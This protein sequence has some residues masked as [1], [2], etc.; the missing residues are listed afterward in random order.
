MNTTGKRMALCLLFSMMAMLWW[1]WFSV[2]PTHAQSTASLETE[3]VAVA[4]ASSF[5]L[6]TG[7][8]AA[9]YC[10]V[11]VALLGEEWQ[12]A[13]KLEATIIVVNDLAIRLAAAEA[14][15]AAL[16]ALNTDTLQPQID[17]INA[18]LANMAVALQ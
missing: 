2:K 13:A 9:E 18:K 11:L 5:I 12:K 1:G 16:Q 10:K 14:A 7:L 15:I 6:P 17:A 3:C 8:T 4:S